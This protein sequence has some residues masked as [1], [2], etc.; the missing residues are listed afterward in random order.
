LSS[1]PRSVKDPARVARARQRVT[2]R[3]ARASIHRLQKVVCDPVRLSIIQALKSGPLCVNDL[4]VVIERA[5]AATSQH[6][7]VLRDVGVVEGSRRGTTIDYRLR[8]GLVTEHM[9][10]VLQAL[11]TAGPASL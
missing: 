7:R 2:P 11:E 6:L 8:A 1:I 5:P 4:A 3:A 10:A 9:E